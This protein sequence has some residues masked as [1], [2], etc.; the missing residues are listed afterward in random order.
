MQDNLACKKITVDK[1]EGRR[2]LGRPNLRWMDGVTKN[3]ERL[4]VR[5]WRIKARDRDGWRRYL[6]RPRPCMGC[7]WVDG[8]IFVILEQKCSLGKR[9]LFSKVT[10][11]C[12]LVFYFNKIIRKTSNIKFQPYAGVQLN[13]WLI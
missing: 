9:Y 6:S 5:N 3:A 4:G 7:A 12:L 11:E 10:T 8:W 2:R 13:R 1:T